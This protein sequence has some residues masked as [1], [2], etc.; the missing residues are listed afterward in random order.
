METIRSEQDHNHNHYQQ[1][2]CKLKT[3]YYLS[4]VPRSDE[5]IRYTETDMYSM[6]RTVLFMYCYEMTPQESLNEIINTGE[7]TFDMATLPKQIKLL[8]MTIITELLDSLF[9]ENFSHVIGRV[10]IKCLDEYRNFWRFYPYIPKITFPSALD[11][12]KMSRF[13]NI[14][15]FKYSQVT[16][17]MLNNTMDHK[18]PM[19]N[20][21]KHLQ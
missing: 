18:I 15:M 12:V 11:F 13:M 10:L 2:Y 8:N 21:V 16:Q 3:N 19:Q 6:V 5:K 20:N 17:F 4:K 9:G 14:T 1:K 7:I